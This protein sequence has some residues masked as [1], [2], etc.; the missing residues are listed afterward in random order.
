MKEAS[1]GC[2]TGFRL[3][4]STMRDEYEQL[5]RKTVI[6]L[7]QQLNERQK[8]YYKT[9][10]KHYKKLYLEVTLGVIS[11]PKKSIKMKCLD[12]CGFEEITANITNCTAINCALWNYRPF[13]K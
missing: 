9:V 12:C 10:P 4:T 2:P 7:E 5:R 3:M 6:K 11:S 13:Q 1:K 8:A